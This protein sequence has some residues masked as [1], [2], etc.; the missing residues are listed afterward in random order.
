RAVEAR[1]GELGIDSDSM[2]AISN[3]FRVATSIRNHM[4]RSVL[5]APDLS[6]TAFTVL[7]VLWI[8]GEQEA[9]HVAD[10]SG[11]SR[12][13]LTGVVTTLERRG[14]V[15][16][17][18]HPGDKR[19]VLVAATEAGESLMA[20]LFPAFNAEE[21]KVSGGLDDAQKAQLADALRTIM[22]TVE[23]LDS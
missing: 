21:A 18:A 14:L 3:I 20:E 10:E 5:A 13:T 2:A 23:R 7:W 16:R 19:S 1:I 8:W 9:R 6:F 15:R 11:V 22:R 17:R 4:E 12:G